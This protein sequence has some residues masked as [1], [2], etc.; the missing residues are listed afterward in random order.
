MCLKWAGKGRTHRKGG[1][2]KTTRGRLLSREGETQNTKSWSL[3]EGSK[4]ERC[5]VGG[6]GGGKGRHL[7]FLMTGEGKGDRVRRERRVSVVF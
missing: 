2:N 4:P 7:E 6:G 1:G 3:T 5:F